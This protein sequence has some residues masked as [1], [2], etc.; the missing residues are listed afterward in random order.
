MHRVPLAIA[1][2]AVLLV[3]G[4]PATE[5]GQ[6]AAPTPE[7]IDR[8]V[9]AA[10]TFLKTAQTRQGMWV[11]NQLLGKDPPNPDVHIGS[12]AL[13]GLA[14]LEAGVP[15]DDAALQAAAKIVRQAAPNL[16]LTYSLS[17]AIMFL[18]RLDDTDPQ[19][20]KLIQTMAVRLLAGQDATGR[21]NYLCPILD[22]KQQQQYL[23]KLPEPRVEAPETDLSNTQFA[24]FALWVARKHEIPTE[25]ALRL[26]DK[27]LR[28]TQLADG[29]WRYSKN[30]ASKPN[31]SITCAGLIGLALGYGTELETNL[32]SRG[33]SEKKDEPKK[34]VFT[35]PDPNKDKVVL[36]AQ[37][38]LADVLNQRPDAGANAQ[39][40]RVDRVYYL[41]WSLERVCMV[42]DWKTLGDKDW[43]AWGAGYL[44]ATQQ[45]DGSWRSLPDPAEE[46]MQLSH[47]SVVETAFAL[48]FLKKS[49]LATDLTAGLKGEVDLQTGGLPKKP[50]EPKNPPKNPGTAKPPPDKDPP[51]VTIDPI[52]A[53]A[54]KLG[55]E[56]VSATGEQQEQVLQRLVQE[57]G[58]PYTLAL[59]DSIPRLSGASKEQARAA[60]AE[61][62]ARMKLDTIREYLKQEDP[63]LRRAAAWAIA[64]KEARALVPELIELLNDADRGVAGIAYAAL[65]EL[66]KQDLGQAPERWQAWWKQQN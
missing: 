63:E 19:N 18:D 9:A 27:S 6:N 17:L 14:L 15:A 40:N 2:L 52:E 25:Q 42:Y 26:V 44:L 4:L 7:Q 57:K 23:D 48:L 29:S 34:E 1:V 47:P 59:A 53:D 21:W 55:R 35:P 33:A 13:A 62:L 49:N 56:L 32:R 54:L 8:S 11:Y 43:Y 66:T 58:G 12:T 61:R 38:Y 51:V 46:P 45:R 22:A 60:L 20:V 24:I 64:Q 30:Q 65:K 50:K 10:I 41:L 3:L 16:K 31:A 5:A 39:A 37:K 28:K 36:A